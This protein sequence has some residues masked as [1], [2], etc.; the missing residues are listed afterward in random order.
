M[1]IATKFPITIVAIAI[2][3]AAGTGVASY[4]SAASNI[5]DITHERLSATAEAKHAVMNDYFQSI[6]VGLVALAANYTTRK[7]ITDFKKGWKKEKGDQKEV[8]Q[9]KYITENKHPIGQKH[10]LEKAGRS[11]YDKAHKKY[12][13][14]Y[15]RFLEDY[16]YSDVFILDAKGNV[17][18]SVYKETDFATNVLTGPDRAS[19]LA[20]AYK[21]AMAGK[22]GEAYFFDFEPYAP[23]QMAP[24]SFLSTPIVIGKGTLGVL[25]LRMPT[26]RIQERVGRFSG[27]GET[28]DV[29]LVGTDHL[30]RT[31]AKSSGVEN[32]LLQTVYQ[33]PLIEVALAGEKGFAQTRD[34]QNHGVFM[35]VEPLDFLGSRFAIV[36][37]QSMD[38]ALQPIYSIRNWVLI[39]SCLF[40]FVAGSAGYLITRRVTGRIGDLVNTMTNLADGN[41]SIAIHGL[42]DPDEVGD[43]A[44]A[45][46]IFKQNAIERLELGEISKS[47][48]QAVASRQKRV[49]ELIAEFD[50]GIQSVLSSVGDT[51]DQMRCTADSLTEIS[52]SVATQTAE[53]TA[54]SGSASENVQSVA[55]AAEQLADSI[56]EIGRQVSEST[57]VVR[58]ATEVTGTATDQVAGLADAAN[59]I[60]EV[61]VLIKDVAEKTNLLALNATIEAARAGEAGRGFAVVATEVKELASQ[62]AN[63]T[64]EISDQISG[65][66]L[67]TGE[68]VSAIG[69]IFDI[70]KKVESYTSTISVAVEEQ[71]AATG[72]ISRSVV[73]AANGTHDVNANINNVSKAVAEAAQ[74]AMQVQVASDEVKAK[75]DQL[76]TSVDSF[77]KNVAAA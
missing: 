68:A 19:G 22:A 73:E 8:L 45:V 36:V 50:S 70:M 54:S 17:L 49:Q 52:G 24:A 26:D 58:Q 34:L 15:R 77:L 40:V 23:S 9:K 32:D 71:S 62:T 66:Q 21:A 37:T 65:I 74:S 25:A 76:R 41:T 75:T 53:A 61:V 20:Q 57:D 39:I 18:Y 44:K 16:G 56:Q 67:A 43:M 6:K 69:S 31:N 4:L 59:R 35:V 60:G 3:T 2:L 14:S 46:E 28:G 63:A 7:A 38:E 10:E 55:S 42:Q 51:L 1:K 72:E 30:L 13:K 29:I 48:E 64:S 47:Q 5:R 33:D 11:S 12:H 27:L